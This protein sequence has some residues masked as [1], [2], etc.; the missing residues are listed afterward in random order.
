MKSRMVWLMSVVVLAGR[1]K[2]CM[3]CL[4]LLVAKLVGKLGK[5][6]GEVRVPRGSEEK[7]KAEVGA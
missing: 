5:K 6:W 2:H 4:G 7:R 1:T 3:R